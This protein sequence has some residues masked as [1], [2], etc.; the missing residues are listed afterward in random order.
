MAATLQRRTSLLRSTSLSTDGRP[1]ETLTEL[2]EILAHMEAGDA[3]RVEALC[4]A[5]VA[6]AQ[7]AALKRLREQE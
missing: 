1:Q 5:H 2:R 6:K 4:R 7:E 3:E